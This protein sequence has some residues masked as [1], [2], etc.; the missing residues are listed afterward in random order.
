METSS[1]TGHSSELLGPLI[2][3]Y[4]LDICYWVAPFML[5]NDFF[6]THTYYL[7]DSDIASTVVN[8]SEVEG[9]EAKMFL[10]EVRVTF[11]QVCNIKLPTGCVMN[12]DDQLW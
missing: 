3:I 1:N 11:P 7:G 4:A 9:E 5:K 12:Y 10:E 2:W 8:E 6:L